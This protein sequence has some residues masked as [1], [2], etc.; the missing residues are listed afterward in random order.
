MTSRREELT[1]QAVDLYSHGEHTG[2]VSSLREAV[3]L[4][5][6]VIREV[7]EDDPAHGGYLANLGTG[8]LS[9]WEATGDDD[10]LREVVT[11]LRSAVSRTGPGHPA[12]WLCVLQLGTVL[13]RQYERLGDIGLLQESVEQWRASLTAAAGEDGTVRAKILSLLGLALRDMHRRTGEE[14]LLAEAVEAARTAQRL[15]PP[16]DP[17]QTAR[18]YN[19]SL[20]LGDLFASTGN[21]AIIAEAIQAGRQALE[22]TPPGT[23]HVAREAGLSRLLLLEAGGGADLGQLI[24]AV[25]ASRAALAATPTIDHAYGTRL[26][27]YAMCLDA[28]YGLSPRPSVLDQE[29]QVLRTAIGA[30]DPQR[31]EHSN[32][33]FLLALALHLKRT[34]GMFGRPRRPPLTPFGRAAARTL[35]AEENDCLE[36]VAASAGVNPHIRL[37]ACLRLA[38]SPV[39]ADQSLGAAER[40]VELLPLTVD[41][42]LIRS[43]RERALGDVGSMAGD[44]AAAAIGD[45]NPARAIVLLEQ[46]RGLLIA[47]LMHTRGSDLA[48]LHEAAPGLA[49]EFAALGAQLAELEAAGR[50]GGYTYRDGLWSRSDADP[51]GDRETQGVL[52]TRRRDVYA[53]WDDLLPRIRAV[54]GCSG[55]L[56]PADITQLAAQAGEGPIV[57]PF[58]S[59]A[60]CGALILTSSSS[61]PAREVALPGLSEDE[62]RR[63]HAALT[64]ALDTTAR[65]GAG[66]DAQA[67][68]EAEIL[69]V[70]AWLWDA[71]TAPVLDALGYIGRADVR[72]LPRI[73][74][75]PVGRLALLPLHAAGHHTRPPATSGPRRPAR[76]RTMFDCAVSSYIPTVR[77]LAYARSHSP[78][79]DVMQAVIVPVPDAPAA[80]PLPGVRAEVTAVSRALP[81]ATALWNAT[82][83]AVRKALPGYAIAHFACHASSDPERPGDSSLVLYD[84]DLA[85]MTIADISALNLNAALAYLSACET[86]LTTP[87]LA[88][89]NVHI[90]GAFHLAGYQHVIGTLWAVADTAAQRLASDFYRQLTADGTAGADGLPATAAAAVALHQATLRL[91]SRFP[92]NPSMWAGFTHTGM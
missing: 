43:D 62:C 13:Y 70:L 4:F 9:L 19:L 84:Y 56:R 37:L 78:G 7:P 88:D 16:D 28:L 74:W 52:A 48:I 79:P 44:I 66:P 21:R 86:G 22:A 40:A 46:V 49:E 89:E 14:A 24:A 26:I 75:C 47:D 25:N 29:I 92:D 50:V 81:G 39:R 61:A 36:K 32:A 41:R 8:L 2:D 54:E 63:R 85:P 12:Y 31:P 45:G 55:F 72:E 38:R 77:S 87:R 73:W 20:T 27:T 35:H 76:P 71:V 6:L 23:Y 1:S 34:R 3:R 67:N 64:K 90:T 18:L 83:D 5:R 17:D 33:L 91:R 69:A 82:R 65:Q 58:T 60:H 80:A 10:I 68:A 53:T 11:M 51:A 42:A 59:S 30:I 57:F 15:T